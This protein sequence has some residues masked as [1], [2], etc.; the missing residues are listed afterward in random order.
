M[1]IFISNLIISMC[2]LCLV[3]ENVLSRSGLRV[4]GALLEVS[5]VQPPAQPMW[6][7]KTIEVHGLDPSTSYDA[8]QLLFESKRRSGGDVVEEMRLDPESNVAFVTFEN[9]EGWYHVW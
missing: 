8:I 7:R 2:V 9:P 3:A 6:D 1:I 4:D 5:A